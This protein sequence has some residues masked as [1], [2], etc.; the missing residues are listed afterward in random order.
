[1][2][3]AV[4]ACAGKT[5]LFFSRA[6][7]EITEARALCAPCPHRDPCLAQAL[8]TPSAYGDGCGVWAGTTPEERRAMR[9]AR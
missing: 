9:R 8:A 5:W 7:E 2:T 6:L 1:M 3:A 4:P